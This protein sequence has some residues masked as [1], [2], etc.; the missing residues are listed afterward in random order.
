MMGGRR[1]PLTR[2]GSWFKP[3]L[4]KKD[5]GSHGDAYDDSKYEELAKE[6]NLDTAQKSD[7]YL[8]FVKQASKNKWIHLRLLADFMQIGRIP[9]DWGQPLVSNKLEQQERWSRASISALEYSQGGVKMIPIASR[10]SKGL[11]IGTLRTK[12]NSGYSPDASFRLYVVED[13]SRNVIEALGTEFNIDPDFFRA[14][15]VDYAWYNVRDRWREAQPLELARGRRNWF[16]LRYVTTRY[17]ENKDE[18]KRA[19]DE[20]KTFNILRRPD[21]DHSKG[22]WDSEEA[23]VAL[24]RCRATF[25]LKPK[26]PQNSTAIGKDTHQPLGPYTWF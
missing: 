19:G 7:R 1:L 5:Y 25:W 22:W 3:E 23:V 4:L 9:R 13:L 11:D 2:T 8:T 15:I 20:A 17:F 26:G 10:K 12:L 6:W 24:T 21:D 14:H 16:Q 18:F